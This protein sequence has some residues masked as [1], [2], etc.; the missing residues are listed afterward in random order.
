M[1]PETDLDF[2]D[3]AV[4]QWEEMVIWGVSG[5][6]GSTVHEAS[7]PFYVWKECSKIIALLLDFESTLKHCI[8]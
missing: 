6:L 3:D 8:H 5:P 2:G 7:N 1:C 4:V